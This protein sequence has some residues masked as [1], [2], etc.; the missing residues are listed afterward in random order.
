MMDTQNY[1][2]RLWLVICATSS[3]K[4]YMIRLSI[5][6]LLIVMDRAALEHYR[7]LVPA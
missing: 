6:E 5:L 3:T 7:N 2:S 1:C 4:M